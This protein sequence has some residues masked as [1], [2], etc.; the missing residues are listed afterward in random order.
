MKKNRLI[1]LFALLLII[2]A[3]GC[4]SKRDTM[5]IYDGQFSEMRI[6]HRMVKQLV[7]H[8]TDLRVEILDEMS[9][10][11]C[12][13]AM[14]KG[15]QDLL[16]SYDGTLLTTFLHLDP[17]DVASGTTLYDFANQK[18]AEKGL[19]LLDKLGNNNTYVLAVP[20]DIADKYG[21]VKVSDLVAVSHELVF[22]AEH[23][24]FTEDG[25]AKFNPM[26]AFYGL[27]FKEAK[28]I[29]LSLKYTAIQNRNIDVTVVYATDGLNRQAK[30][31]TLEDDLSFF[32]EYNGA[33]LVREDLFTRFSE[34]APN[35][36]DILNL[37]GGIFT[38]EDMVDLTYAVDIGG[39]SPD[40]VARE[41]LLAKG[42]LN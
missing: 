32:P 40:A 31:A 23:E 35:L 41:Y 38:N 3:A 17:S 4:G 12:Y 15:N 30:L 36:K 19:I 28:Q 26:A 27:E 18:A 33:L 29:D 22:G 5:R 24:F 7:E 10:T 21:L 16:N 13:N 9:P 37:L 25:S 8:Y 1:M 11:N 20:Q 6:I 39:Q 2:F 42:L 34:A 14:L